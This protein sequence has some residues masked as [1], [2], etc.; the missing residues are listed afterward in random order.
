MELARA[1]LYRYDGESGIGGFLRGW[2]REPGFRLVLHLRLCRALRETPLTRWGV[3]HA[4]RLLYGRRC[5]RY[6]VYL[7]PFMELGGGLFVPHPL[8]I[9]VATHVSIGSNCNLSQGVTIGGDRRGSF[10]GKPTIGDRVFIGPGAVIFGGISLGDDCAVGANS[11]VTRPVEAGAVV[12]GVP[13]RCISKAGS[14]GY[15][16]FVLEELDA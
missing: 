13:A 6:G 5:V 1:D 11:V 8:S 3:Y 14:A 7:D 9:I 12:V 15:I 4:C 2:W 10:P 16:N